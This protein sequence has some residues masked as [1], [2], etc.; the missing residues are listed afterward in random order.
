MTTKTKAK[1]KAKKTTTK[2][3]KAVI[4]A[5]E[6]YQMIQQTAY[7]FAEARGFVPGHETSDWI[8]AEQ[9]IENALQ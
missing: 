7:Y 1:A 4:S 8:Q 2:K 6:K 3:T 9:Q 5:E